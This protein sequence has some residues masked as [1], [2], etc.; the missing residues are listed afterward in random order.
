MNFCPGCVRVQGAGRGKLEGVYEKMEEPSQGMPCYMMSSSSPGPVYLYWLK[1]KWKLG[2]V[3]GSHKCFALTDKHKSDIT[4]PCDR[5]WVWKLYDK[6]TGDYMAAPSSFQVVRA[7]KPRKKRKLSHDEQESGSTHA[8]DVPKIK[9]DTSDDR[10]RQQESEFTPQQHAFESKLRAMLTKVS[11]FHEKQK[12][13]ELVAT[14][15]QSK[16]INRPGLTSELALDVLA[17]V[18]EEQPPASTLLKTSDISQSEAGDKSSLGKETPSPKAPKCLPPLNT[19][20]P[21]SPLP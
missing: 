18:W 1:G 12:K 10:Y 19:P 21:V 3:L 6:E 4:N 2:C 17:K 11:T 14:K 13:L 16:E 7:V 15:L 8:Q 5:S 9:A 20:S